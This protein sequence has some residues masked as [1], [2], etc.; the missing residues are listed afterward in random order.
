MN[1]HPESTGGPHYDPD[2]IGPDGRM[3]RFHKGQKAP[4]ET[5]AQKRAAKLQEQLLT[6]QLKQI[7]KGSEVTMP[8]APPAP[9]PVSPPP[10]QTANDVSQ[11]QMDARKQAAKRKGLLRSVLAGEQ[12]PAQTMGGSTMLS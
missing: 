4:E 10:T 3:A 6:A 1:E 11:A 12:R 2:M 9:G 8:E 5:A 7:K